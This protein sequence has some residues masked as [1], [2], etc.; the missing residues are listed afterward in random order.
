MKTFEDLEFKRHPLAG[1]IL[2]EAVIAKM[3][4][5]NGAYISVIGGGV[6]MYGDGKETFEV[7]TLNDVHGHLTKEEV[8]AEMLKLQEVR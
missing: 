3:E 6:G 5:E 4:F 8:T 1:S 7:M 2:G